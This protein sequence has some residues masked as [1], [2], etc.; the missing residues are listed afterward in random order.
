MFNATDPNRTTEERA[1]RAIVTAGQRKVNLIWEL[2]QA[3]IAFIIV[4]S[5]VVA[6]LHVALYHASGDQTIPPA[7]KDAA[8]MVI[9]FY[10]NRTNSHKIGGVGEKATDRETYVGR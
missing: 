1:E 9:V 7:L 3:A 4:A 10:F 5:N 2:T 8:L 6:G